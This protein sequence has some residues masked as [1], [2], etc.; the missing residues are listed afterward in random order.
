MTFGIDPQVAWDKI[1]SFDTAEELKDYFVGGHVYGVRSRAFSCP[2][3]IWM[4]E[5]TGKLTHVSNNVRVGV[6]YKD[7]L[8][9]AESVFQHTQVTLDFMKAFDGKKYPELDI[10]INM[11]E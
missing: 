10:K 3:A 1:T 2:I 6:N 7:P 9:G 4:S 5:Q 8:R 11:E